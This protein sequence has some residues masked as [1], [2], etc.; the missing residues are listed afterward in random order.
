[1]SYP[2]GYPYPVY[3]APYVV[4]YQV[5]CP[6]SHGGMSGVIIIKIPAGSLIHRTRR[7]TNCR[8]YASYG[9]RGASS[10]DHSDNHNSHS[11]LVVRAMYRKI[12]LANL[13]FSGSEWWTAGDNS[14]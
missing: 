3:G 5:C 4:T 9:T 1:M 10:N 8:V 13:K 12:N 11:W 14:D 7:P 2:Y 6:S